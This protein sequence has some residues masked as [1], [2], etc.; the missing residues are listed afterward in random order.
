[1][2]N[3]GIEFEHED[4]KAWLE[5]AMVAEI[6]AVLNVTGKARVPVDIDAR[7]ARSPLVR[8]RGRILV[9]AAPSTSRYARYW[10]RNPL[11]KRM[12]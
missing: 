6:D 5:A 8:G 7:I 10:V 12:P 9:N 2:Q 4:A 3:A 1:M 11:R